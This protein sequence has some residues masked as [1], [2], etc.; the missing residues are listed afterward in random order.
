MIEIAS[1]MSRFQ[2]S[3]SAR[4]SQIARDLAARGRDIVRLTT[5]E[6]DFPTPEHVKD[7]A[8]EAMRR[9]QTKY[10]SIDGTPE[11]KR[12]V[13]AKFRRDHGLEYGPDQIMVGNGAKQVIFNAMMATLEPGDEVIVPVPYYVSYAD[14]TRLAEGTPVFV[15]CPPERGFK[16]QPADLEA[17]ITPRTRWLV[18]NSPGNPTGAVYSQPELKTLGAVLLRHPRVMVLT[19]DIYEHILFDGRTYATIAQAEPGLYDRTLTVNGVSKAYAMT[20]WRIGYG[21]GPKEL[22]KAMAKVQSQ[23]THAAC[24]ISQAAAVAALEGPQQ[25]VVERSRMFQSRRDFVVDALN[26]VS[27]LSVHAPEGAFYVFPS[28]AGLIGKRTPGGQVLGTDRDVANYLLEAEGVAVMD[29]ASYGQSPYIRL[30]IASSIEVLGEACTRIA[31][32]CEV[33]R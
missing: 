10:T 8:I 1:R 11:L 24:S 12:A 3:A 18:L 27:G 16:L 13:A 26:R 31:R 19:D 21:G 5:G 15:Q 14:I 4:A 6:P 33:L 17:A 9:E 28:C 7:A 25:L 22:V 29:G 2:E 20:G 30:S 23:C 32:A